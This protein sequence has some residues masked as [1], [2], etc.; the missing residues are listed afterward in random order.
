MSIYELAQAL[1]M[2]ADAEELA[3]EAIANMLGA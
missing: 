1:G 2:A 3:M